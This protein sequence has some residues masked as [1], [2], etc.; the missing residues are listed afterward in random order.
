[1]SFLC[2][3]IYSITKLKK[4]AVDV[5]AEGFS[6]IQFSKVKTIASRCGTEPGPASTCKIS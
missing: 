4:T 2:T 1:M 5:K 6:L 3:T